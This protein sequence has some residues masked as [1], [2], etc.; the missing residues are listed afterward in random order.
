MAQGIEVPGGP[1]PTPPRGP[2][3]RPRGASGRSVAGPRG[4]AVVVGGVGAGARGAG[5]ASPRATISPME[6]GAGAAGAVACHAAAVSALGTSTSGDNGWWLT[7]AWWGG[8][9]ME[10]VVAGAGAFAA[11]TPATPAATFARAPVPRRDQAC[12]LACLRC[13][14]SDKT[15]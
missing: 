6:G 10:G 8:R 1:G 13:S 9:G 7:G 4:G 11:R 12:N 5:G 2:G 15:G 14:S 3:A